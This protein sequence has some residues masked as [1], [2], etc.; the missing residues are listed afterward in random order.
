MWN[1]RST[2]S[3]KVPL[4]LGILSQLCW[5]PRGGLW[6]EAPP[7]GPTWLTGPRPAR[8]EGG[9]SLLLP[10]LSLKFSPECLSSLSWVNDGRSKALFGNR[11]PKGP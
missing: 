4:F 1:L 7:Q 6:K 5:E 2:P 8:K 9:L 3:S 10:P 11:F